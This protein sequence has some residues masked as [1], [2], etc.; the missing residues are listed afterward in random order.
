MLH[1]RDKSLD[2][3]PTCEHQKCMTHTI[4]IMERGK[5]FNDLKFLDLILEKKNS[6]Y[7]LWI[8]FFFQNVGSVKAHSFKPQY[9]GHSRLLKILN[10]LSL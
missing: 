1:Y 2:E 4:K 6:E 8:F 3:L 5:M 9:L 10:H 7:L